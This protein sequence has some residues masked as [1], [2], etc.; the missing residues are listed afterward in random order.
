MKAEKICELTKRIAEGEDTKA[1]SRT[2]PCY[3]TRT[4]K[5]SFSE[6]VYYILHPGKESANLGLKRFFLR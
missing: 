2:K 1:E 4:R 3:F 6:V 5:M